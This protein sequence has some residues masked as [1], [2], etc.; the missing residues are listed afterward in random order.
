VRQIQHSL[1]VRGK[2][3]HQPK[4]ER[5]ERF[6]HPWKTRFHSDFLY[7]EVQAGHGLAIAHTSVEASRV[8]LAA[9]KG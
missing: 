1:G 7:H 2:D 8:S 5:L 6:F 9:W 4:D 3:E